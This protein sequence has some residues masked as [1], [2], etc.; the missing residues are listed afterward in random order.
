MKHSCGDASALLTKPPSP[1]PGFFL[2]AVTHAE[3]R[4]QWTPV[5]L[6][7]QA[8]IFPLLP[9]DAQTNGLR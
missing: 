3:Y 9:R 7:W 8:F 5:P 4:G 6:A 2:T 1:A